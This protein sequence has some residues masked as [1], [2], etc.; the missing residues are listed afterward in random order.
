MTYRLIALLSA[1]VFFASCAKSPPATKQIATTRPTTVPTTFPATTQAKVDN[2]VPIDQPE[3]P[4]LPVPFLTGEEA[5]AKFKVAPGF[6]VELV[7]EEPMVEH[8]VAIAFDA[9]GRMWVCEMRGYMPDAE[10]NNEN[11]PYGRVSVLEDTDGDGRMDKSTVFLDKLVLPRAISLVR[12][13][14]LV[15]VPPKLL[16]CR[17]TN[18]DGVSDEQ[19]VVDTAY[20]D[21][22]QPEHQANGLMYGIDNWL[23]SANHDK[24]YRDVGGKWVS[25]IVP[26]EGQWGITQDDF[27]R[28]FHDT[29]S[30]YLRGDVVAARYTI[31]NPYHRGSGANVAIDENQECWPA[32]PSAV[33]RG[34]RENF[35]RDGRLRAFTA[36]CGPTVY[37]GGIFPQG[38]EG[39]VFVCESSAN[40]IRRSVLTE[41]GLSITGKNAYEQAEFLA[42]SYERFRPVNLTVG[43][44]GALYVVDMHHGLIQHRQ[45]LTP[46]AKS[47]YLKR[48]LNKYL[49]TGRIYRIV[50]D[51]ATL[52]PKPDLAKAKSSELVAKLAHPNGWWRDTAQRLLVERADSTSTARL[53]EV[54]KSGPTPQARVQAL[55]TLEGMRRLDPNAVRIALADEHPQ[56]RAHAIRSAEFLL[57]SARR[58]EIVPDLIK[59]GSDTDPLVELQF[60]LTVSEIAT[61]EAKVA[62][63]G[64]LSRTNH[65][66][67]RDAAVSGLRGRELEFLQ[68][69]LSD[70]AWA[71][72]SDERAEMITVL[73]GTIVAQRS[74]KQVAG[75]LDLLADQTGETQWR[76]EAIVGGMR[77]RMSKP[78][79]KPVILASEPQVY[80]S[81]A[82]TKEIADKLVWLGKAGYVPPPPPKPLTPKEQ[83][84]FAEGQKVYA[85]VCVQCHKPDGLGAPGLAPPL[86]GSEWTAGSEERL[87]RIVLHGLRGPITVN[88]ESYNLDMPGWK[89][90]SDEQIAA[91]LTYV[92]RSWENEA[93]PVS[94]GAV[95]RIRSETA[96]RV[97]S[98]RE[99]ELIRLSDRATSTRPAAPA[100]RPRSRSAP[101]V[102]AESPSPSP[103]RSAPPA[104][105]GSGGS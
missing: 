18:G 37:R 63:A 75:L 30:N 54:L 40:L 62:L 90:L 83:E 98:W 58:D 8:P 55:W 56:V 82:A 104:G 12:D 61:P 57:A 22:K 27:G 89:M 15:A 94:P 88:G 50:P 3:S 66:Y 105:A 68:Q 77:D 4:D 97:E 45:Y 80:T 84:R 65:K 21:A 28:L 67:I 48:E 51:G 60:A 46:Y 41:S 74:P 31:R 32:I 14:L 85:S 1:C 19:T 79:F 44:D 42:S 26:E 100:S 16:F 52:Y 76:R 103:R 39:N 49:S 47:K 7:A 73:A 24:R 81:L 99:R 86:A 36:A 23:Y 71:A 5:I 6:R 92:R 72:A 87:V 20:G 17:D 25:D 53:R 13:G 38:F 101:P 29:N 64:V 70:P 95:A 43:P 93:P 2:P 9:G 69:L 10:G 78:A 91:A 102:A 11:E 33:N 34:Y 35:L 59:A 96:S